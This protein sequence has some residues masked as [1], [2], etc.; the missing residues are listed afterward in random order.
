MLVYLRSSLFFIGVSLLVVVF[1]P[2][3]LILAFFPLRIRHQII[4]QN[5]VRAVM[6]WLRFTCGLDY[7]VIFKA[8]LPK[9]PAIIM[10]K[11]QSAWETLAMQLIMPLHVW[12]LKQELLWIPFFGWQLK[13][14]GPIAINRQQGAL[15][16]QQLLTQ[17]KKRV[18]SGFW[19]MIFPEGTRIAPGIRGKYKY[20]GARLAT[21]LNLPIIPIAHNAGEFW[22]KKS[23]R[24]YPGTISVI[25]GEPI[26][27]A[28]EEMRTLTEKVETWIENEMQYITGLGPK[29]PQ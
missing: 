28:Q 10:C 13:M 1:I 25:V 15:A 11:H 16:Q 2:F 27:P 9:G 7:R 12:V 5:W 8:P 17:G 18:D 26:Y 3:T 21:A 19:I 29:G 23:I 22:P 20:G 24:K 14:M 4:T 6:F